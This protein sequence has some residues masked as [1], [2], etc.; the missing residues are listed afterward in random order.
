[1]TNFTNKLKSF[2]AKNPWTS[3]IS[4]FFI[5]LIFILII[6]RVILTPTII[7][8]TT[9]WLKD[10]GIDATIE[11]ISLHI[12]GGTVTLTNA[13]GT[14]NGQPLF[15]IGHVDLHWLWSPLSNKKVEVS[16][17]EVSHLV[18]RIKDYTDTIVVGGVH[19][20]VSSTPETADNNTEITTTNTN[21]KPWAASLGEVVFSDIDVC[22]LQHSSTIAEASNTNR[23]MDYCVRLN[24]MLWSGTISYATDAELL[25]S[26]DLPLSSTGDFTL[27]GLTVTDNI[28]NKT[29]LDSKLNTLDKVV[30]NGLNDIQADTL[31]MNELHAMHRDDDKHKDSFR[32]SNLT[33]KK[34]Q[35]RNLNDL[36][37]D[38]LELTTPGIY[39]VKNKMNDWEYQQWIPDLE[40]ASAENTTTKQKETEN[41]STE[42]PEK[43]LFKF[44]INSIN[45][46]DADFCYLDKTTT[47][48]YCYTH[49]NLNW[50]GPVSYGGNLGTQPLVSINGNFKLTQP[51]ITNKTIDRKLFSIDALNINKLLVAGLN[52]NDIQ[53]DSLMVNELHAMQR[54]DDKHKDSFRFS[55]LTLKKIQLRNLNDLSIDNLELKTPGIYIVKNKTNDWEYQQWMPQVKESATKTTT[56][57]QEES[58]N[59]TTKSDSV[60][61]FAFNNINIDDAD[62]CYLD[63]TTSFYYCYTHKA[64]AWSGPINYGGE[65]KTQPPVSVN[66]N[67]KLTHPLISNNTI[68]RKLVDI[69]ALKINKLIVTG[70]KARLANFDIDKFS[71]L[72]RDKKDDYT[73]RFTTLK[74]NDVD[75]NTDA[76]AINSIDL[77]DLEGDISINKDGSWEFDKWRP[78]SKNEAD[79]ADNKKSEETFDLPF[80]PS[81]PRGPWRRSRRS[82]RSR[83]LATG[84]GAARARW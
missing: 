75:Y 11:D 56:A 81:P 58:E 59:Q 69:E 43:S 15:N 54:D 2:Y 83:P 78:E 44:A 12:I 38:N 63:K 50:S 14:E 61:K 65:M 29:L 55:N 37:I 79:K 32:F 49:K 36:S 82:P 4:L 26:S 1:M 47:L 48:Y 28:L 34:I 18:V 25:K 39:I 30:I 35:L 10:R 45:I 84:C 9:S 3:R 52:A 20:P 64:L 68:G 7:Q 42:T 16:H 77:K 71:A 72:Q 66:G 5:S 31:T 60:F 74:I 22:Y 6:I 40:K 76:L 73:V 53:V 57:K 46:D 23:T 21:V 17:I 51:L 33:L 27:N 24:E 67:L 62:F 41:Q 70:Q 19:I 80:P 13:T 8:L